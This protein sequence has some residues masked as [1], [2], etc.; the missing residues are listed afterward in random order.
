M[1]ADLCW[2]EAMRKPAVRQVGAVHGPKRAA[3]SIETNLWH[4][5]E[6]TNNDGEGGGGGGMQQ[7]Q[8]KSESAD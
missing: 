7:W 2:D 4:S 6:R 5:A 3:G 1:K 8:Q